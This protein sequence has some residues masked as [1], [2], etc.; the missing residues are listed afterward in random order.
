VAG[1]EKLGHKVFQ[2]FVATT[3]EQPTTNPF[4]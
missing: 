2:N 1:T 4:S 3:S